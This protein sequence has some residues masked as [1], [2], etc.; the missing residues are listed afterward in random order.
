MLPTSRPAISFFAVTIDTSIL[1]LTVTE[2]WPREEA[3]AEASTLALIPTA[4]DPPGQRTGS[5]VGERRKCL[6]QKFAGGL[7]FDPL[8]TTALPS[9]AVFSTIRSHDLPFSPL[10][11]IWRHCGDL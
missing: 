4:D 6:R 2:V 3:V 5:I 9:R 8:S 10:L 7:A 11:D 1:D